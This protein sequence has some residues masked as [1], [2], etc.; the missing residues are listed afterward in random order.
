MVCSCSSTS[1]LTHASPGAPRPSAT[2]SGSPG[3]TRWAKSDASG[4][5]ATQPPGGH[6]GQHIARPGGGRGQIIAQQGDVVAIL[7]DRVAPLDFSVVI[8]RATSSA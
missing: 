4:S 3:P 5:G 7:S 2:A 8:S 1:P 6:Q